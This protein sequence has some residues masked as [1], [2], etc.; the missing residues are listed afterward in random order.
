MHRAG[1][2][3]TISRI[4]SIH[5]GLKSTPRYLHRRSAALRCNENDL[6]E[7]T[8]LRWLCNDEIQ[9]SRRYIR[10]DVDALCEI[11]AKACNAEECVSVRKID[12]GSFNR[13][14]GLTLNDGRE[15]IARLPFPMAGPPH[16]LT[17]SEVA[18]LDFVRNIMSIPVPKVLAWS[19][20]A[21]STPVGAEFMILEKV[22]GVEIHKPWTKIRKDFGEI[23]VDLLKIDK[24]YV[25]TRFS[26]NGS[27]FYKDDVIGHPHTTR[28]FEDPKNETEDT[29][30]FAIGSHMAWELW[31]GERVNMKIDR[32][33]WSSATDYVTG[34]I[35]CQQE[36]LRQFVLPRSEQDP[37]FTSIDGSTPKDHILF[38]E[39]ALLVHLTIMCNLQWPVLWHPDLHRANIFVTDSAPYTI[40]GLIDWQYASISPLFSQASIPKAFQYTGSR[41]E[42]VRDCLKPPLPENFDSLSEEDKKLTLEEQLDAGLHAAYERSTKDISGVHTLLTHNHLSILMQSFWSSQVSWAEGL[43]PV[44]MCLAA[45]YTEWQDATGGDPTRRCPIEFNE[46]QLARIA[47]I[48]LRFLTYTGNVKALRDELGCLQDG[49]VAVELFEEALVKSKQREAEWDEVEK[50]GPYPFRDGYTALAT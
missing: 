36:W 6:F 26:M 5:R 20:R 50:C 25:N 34:F 9:R 30:R 10:F 46:D 35:R 24:K 33:P 11:A 45:L 19:S 18:T 2:S 43:A 44:E 32:G 29:Q 14:L 38:L 3:R 39:G 1:V 23:I 4:I 28:I 27:L 16:L 37:S 12:E 31:H 15:V 49:S 41:V 22:E 21:A 8:S 17:A 48:Q 47:H 7:Y 13:I 40:T 42:F